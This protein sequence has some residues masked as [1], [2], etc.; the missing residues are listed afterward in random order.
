MSAD[1]MEAPVIERLERGLATPVAAEATSCSRGHDSESERGAALVVSGAVAGAGAGRV[2]DLL[3]RDPR[4][5]V[6]SSIG[7]AIAKD[8]SVVVSAT[9]ASILEESDLLARAREGTVAA[10]FVADDDARRVALFRAGAS[11][12]LSRRLCDAEIHCRIER[13]L[14]AAARH[15]ASLAREAELETLAYTDSLTGLSN[16]RFFDEIL[17][18]EVARANRYRRPMSLVLI[19]VDHFKRINDLLGH[20]AGDAFL[21]Q[22]ATQM[23]ASTRGCD[24]AARFGG[25][26]LGA[27]LADIDASGAR[28]YATRIVEAL[29]QIPIL[30]DAPEVRCSLSIGIASY[31]IEPTTPAALIQRA[32]RAL[33]RAKARGRG[34]I[35]IERW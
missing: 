24:C 2:V 12:V 20:A 29:S 23:K 25:D 1:G 27:I 13:A 35:E 21:V 6:V 32:D 9:P 19:D 15:R 17:K 11:D 8:V 10:L 3:R 34:R 28:T 4:F 7:E 16:R 22:V 5:R 33:Y 26:E 18:R 14:N 30:P 31:G